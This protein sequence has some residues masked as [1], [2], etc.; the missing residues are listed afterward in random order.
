MPLLTNSPIESADLP[1]TPPWRGAADSRMFTRCL[2]I[3]SSQPRVGRY[4]SSATSRLL[5]CNA[6]L[7]NS[8][9]SLKRPHLS[10]CNPPS[11]LLH[12]EG[13]CLP[14]SWGREVGGASEAQD[15]T[16]HRCNCQA[17]EIYNMWDGFAYSKR[18]CCDLYAG[19][20][21]GS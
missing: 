12:N 15:H 9:S 16:G 1:H 14:S 2:Q 4:I 17:H 20:N 7:Q 6:D 18:R 10:T 13:T 3:S 21:S 19:H 11:F 8:P 5:D